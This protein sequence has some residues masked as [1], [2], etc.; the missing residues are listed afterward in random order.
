MTAAWPIKSDV[1]VWVCVWETD[2]SIFSL[3]LAVEHK[4]PS[5]HLTCFALFL[6]CLYAEWVTPRRFHCRVNWAETPIHQTSMCVVF[7]NRREKREREKRPVSYF[8]SVWASL[9]AFIPSRA[10]PVSPTQR[11]G[12]VRGRQNPCRINTKSSNGAWGAE[13]LHT[14]TKFKDHLLSFRCLG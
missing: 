3:F 7:A 11:P 6:F 10:V 8:S 1:C 4:P 13:T 2:S 9:Q 12:A 5:F 14:A